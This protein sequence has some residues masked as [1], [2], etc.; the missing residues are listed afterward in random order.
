MINFI[1]AVS[2]EGRAQLLDEAWVM[3]LEPKEID[4]LMEVK[5]LADP[6]FKQGSIGAKTY[7]VYNAYMTEKYADKLETELGAENFIVLGAWMWSG[8]Q[9]GQAEVYNVID[10]EMVKSIE[11]EPLHPIHPMLLEV[12]PDDVTYDIDGNQVGTA[13]ATE[14]KQV[15]LRSGQKPR[16]WT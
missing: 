6:I 13:P 10:D 4:K 11:G 9:L 15:I 2:D 16:R 1:V 8:L 12:M 7:T 5:S 3:T 14:Y